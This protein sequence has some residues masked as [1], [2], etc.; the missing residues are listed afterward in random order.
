MITLRRALGI[1]ALLV[2]P[3]TASGQIPWETPQ[4]LAPSAPRGVSL[5][6]ASYAAAPGDGW[7]VMV[8]FRRADAPTGLGFRIAGGQGSGGRNAIA[9][10]V[11]ASAWITRASNA[12]P[13][14]VIWTSGIGGS[15]GSSMQVALPV[16]IAASR[17]FGQETVWFNPYAASRVIIEGR[18]GGRAPDD[19][20]D[21]QLATE[22]GANFAFDR[23]RRFI[24]RMAAAIG[25][26][27]ALALGAHLGGGRRA[28]M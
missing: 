5:M 6:A 3:G 27:S 7:G 23:N 17:S 2:T 22:V 28:V 9:A 4:L 13:V 24:V 21:M 15:Y 10:G 26:R 25:D 16:G 18:L 14:D 19:E 12:F 11:E 1:V 20:L 8:A